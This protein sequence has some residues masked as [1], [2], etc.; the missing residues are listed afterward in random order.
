M[1]SF[2]TLQHTDSYE[3]MADIPVVSKVAIKLQGS[4]TF[5]VKTNHVAAQWLAPS[6]LDNKCHAHCM[7]VVLC[8]H[9]C[10]CCLRRIACQ[11]ANTVSFEQVTPDDHTLTIRVEKPGVCSLFG[12]EN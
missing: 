1:H 5:R 8:T 7:V 10:L 9:F 4:Q 6:N 11:G 2:P 3:L 12:Y